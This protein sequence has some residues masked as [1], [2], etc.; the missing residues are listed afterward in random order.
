MNPGE[1]NL[2]F[3]VFPTSPATETPLAASLLRMSEAET[4]QFNIPELMRPMVAA[5]VTCPKSWHQLLNLAHLFNLTCCIHT[6]VFLDRRDHRKVGCVETRLT[7]I[8]LEATREHITFVDPSHDVLVLG[9]VVAVGP[10][11]FHHL[12]CRKNV[13]CR[14]GDDF[15]GDE[16]L[17]GSL[18]V[19][20]DANE[21]LLRIP[22][23]RRG[24][25]LGDVAMKL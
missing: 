18:I 23:H 24:V 1:T 19:D 12:A 15:Y 2:C 5:L 7:S 9:A 11:G 14:T 21:T 22:N 13:A 17:E 25:T 6:Q 3:F 8:V 10:I 20:A 16:V 4:G